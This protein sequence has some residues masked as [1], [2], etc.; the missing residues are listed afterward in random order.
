MVKEKLSVDKQ[1][2]KMKS[3]GIGF[4]II[5]EDEAKEF[6]SDNTYYFK[7]KSFQKNYQK[8]HANVYSN[9]EFAYLKDF[10]TIDMHFRKLI[11]SMVLNI[12]HFL[13]VRLN[14]DI[15]DNTAEDGYSIVENF[16][17]D[18][19]NG[20]IMSNIMR[21]SQSDYSGELINKYIKGKTTKINNLDVPTQCPYWVLFEVLSFGDF[22]K[23]YNF[24]YDKYNISNPVK[25]LLF[26]VK[27]L[28][29]AGA[30]NNCIL[31]MLPKALHQ[32]FNS[33]KELS[34]IISNKLTITPDSR[35]N[36]LSVPVLHDFA[37]LCIVFNMVVTSTPV[38]THTREDFESFMERL[39]K[40]KEYYAKNTEIGKMRTFFKKLLDIF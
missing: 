8:N 12:E 32:G 24:Y 30:H 37:A 29:N 3:N 1:I 18:S 38:K 16:F 27:C 15:S 35:K 31:N 11:L 40:H 23:F 25:N 28:R 22:I 2:E 4:N 36:C 26:P 34:S 39:D 10:S 14:K 13:K 20:Y 33:N 5:A 21:F 19:I 9:L 17:K 7:I 6:L